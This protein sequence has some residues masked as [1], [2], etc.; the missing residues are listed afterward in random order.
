MK[1][2]GGIKSTT[3]QVTTAESGNAIITS[4]R[5][6]QKLLAAYIEGN[7]YI[8]LTYITGG[9]DYYGAHVQDTAGTKIASTTVTLRLIYAE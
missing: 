9:M 3:E 4:V 7:P 6:T 1:V 5:V 2:G 8:A